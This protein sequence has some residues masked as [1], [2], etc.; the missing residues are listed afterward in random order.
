MKTLLSAAMLWAAEGAIAGGAIL[1]EDGRILAVGPRAAMTAPA[2]AR[3]RDWGAA[4]L[5]P[6]LVDIHVHGGAGLDFMT[7]DAAGVRAVARRLARHGVT[8]FCATTVTA[9]WDDVLAAVRRLAAAGCDIHLE[10]PFLSRE[11]RGVHPETQLLAPSPHRLDELWERSRERL[12]IV[13]LAPELDGAPEFIAAARARGITVALGHSDATAAQALAGV[14]AGATHVTHTFNAM[15]P[16]HQ[17]EPGLLGVA[18]TEP[19]LTADVIADGEHVDPRL[20]AMLWRLQ[21]RERTVLISDAISATGCPEGEYALGGITV[22]V[23]GG[24]CLA[25]GRLAGSVL[26]LDRAVTNFMRFTGCDWASAWALASRNAAR[27]AGLNRKGQMETGADADLVV[28]AKDG[29]VQA[30]YVAGQQID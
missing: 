25:G 8:S 10:G 3:E 11:R 17:R 6:G 4:T 28:L 20:I 22:A 24:R 27:A 15:R 29:T 2:G 18:L 23:T 16:L 9:P 7:A 26:T 5:A 19:G 13:T 12:R 14:R 30:A 1:I 21:G